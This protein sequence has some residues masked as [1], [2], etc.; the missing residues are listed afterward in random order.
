MKR[1]WKKIMMN[2]WTVAIGSGLVLSLIS[3]VNDL[4]NKKQVFS[5][6]STIFTKI[7]NM[8]IA[9][10][11]YRI[12]LW[13]L[14]VGIIILIL[15]LVIFLQYWDYKTAKSDIIDFTEYVQDEILEYKWR[16]TWRKNIY[17]KYCIENLHPICSRCNT[18]LVE[19]YC[20]YG[21]KYK[22]LRCN[23]GYSKPMPDVEHVKMLITDN[24]RGKY[25]PND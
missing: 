23:M 7:W 5:T 8:F 2:P 25:F 9:I 14:L 20:G 11:N 19:D 3:V 1:K 12:K 17:G 4:I 6:I 16:W 15:I 18:P 22:C 10:L 13:W 24:V 21:G